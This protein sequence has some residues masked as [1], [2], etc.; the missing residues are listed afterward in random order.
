MGFLKRLLGGVGPA[1][2]TSDETVSIPH[3]FFLLLGD[4]RIAAEFYETRERGEPFV[5]QGYVMTGP[6]GGQYGLFSD[7]VLIPWEKAGLVLSNVA[8]VTHHPKA[9]QRMEFVPPTEVA[10]VPEPNNEY[11]RNAIAVWDAHR[12]IQLGY[13]PREVAAE[14]RFDGLRGYVFR[15]YREVRSN[16]RQGLKL[17]IGPAL[18]LEIPDD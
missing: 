17:V 3:H 12:T 10:L 4:L 6:R 18:A 11:D 8:G 14:L 2:P 13:L 16:R 5:S 15:E 9:L 1:A 7:A